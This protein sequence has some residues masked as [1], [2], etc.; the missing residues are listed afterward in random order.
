MAAVKAVG[1]VA[2]GFRERLPP[3]KWAHAVYKVTE[4]RR[5]DFVTA[6]ALCVVDVCVCVCVCV[7][8]NG[9]RS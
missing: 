4:P 2:Y 9:K 7:C 3:H 8:D 1:W 6:F 5:D